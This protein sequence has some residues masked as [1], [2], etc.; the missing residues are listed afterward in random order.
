MKTLALKWLSHV[1]SILGAS[2]VPASVPEPWK[3]REGWKL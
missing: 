3:T 2:Q 1:P